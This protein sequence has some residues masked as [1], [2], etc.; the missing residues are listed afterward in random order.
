MV[1]VKR[2]RPVPVVVLA[3]AGV[4]VGGLG[5]VGG[6]T[7][8]ALCAGHAG[9]GAPGLVVSLRPAEA[10]HLRS[11]VPGFVAFE[12]LLPVAALLLAALVLAAGL[13]LLTGRRGARAAALM[14]AGAVLLGGL[15]VA[16]YDVLAVLPGVEHLHRSD[17]PRRFFG[18][19][20][21]PVPPDPELHWV[22]LLFAVGGLVF[23]LHAVATLV[24]LTSPAVVEAFRRGPGSAD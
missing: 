12:V 11:A 20:A 23:V 13:G 22:A 5:L 10:E 2:E 6:G 24:I 8:A 3:L 9:P 18:K 7:A 14:A 19:D 16:L 1:V 17:F 21:P 15:V 4:L